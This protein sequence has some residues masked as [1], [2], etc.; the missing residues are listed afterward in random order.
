MISINRDIV[1]FWIG[2][3]LAKD[4]SFFFPGHAVY[5]YNLSYLKIFSI[6]FRFFF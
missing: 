6:V 5:L 3:R 2:F 1:F 4:N